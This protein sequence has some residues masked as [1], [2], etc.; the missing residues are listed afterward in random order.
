[1]IRY[2]TQTLKSGVSQM[3]DVKEDEQLAEPQEASEET[4]QETPENPP[5]ES[6]EQPPEEPQKPKKESN[7][8][9]PVLTFLLVLLGISEAVFWGYFALSAYSSSLARE[10]YEQQQKAL[11][12]EQA[13]QGIRGGSSYSP[14]LKVENGV[15]TWERDKW[16]YAG[17]SQSANTSAAAPQREDGLRLASV[18]VVKVPY[19]LAQRD[20]EE[21]LPSTRPAAGGAAPTST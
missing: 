4:P 3:A 14:N 12:E 1:M 18:P 2:R 20:T 6:P 7:I 19:R 9:I 15:V 5:Q 17:S 21:N 11:V 16:E 8:L 13:S 10:R